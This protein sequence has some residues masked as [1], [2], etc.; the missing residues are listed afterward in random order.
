MSDPRLENAWEESV[1][2]DSEAPL[3][4]KATE[5][6]RLERKA[7]DYC[8]CVPDP[9]IES[10]NLGFM[11]M[12][13]LE[14]VQ[15]RQF[16]MCELHF[17]AHVKGYWMENLFT[18]LPSTALGDK[19]CDYGSNP[20]GTVALTLALRSLNPKIFADWAQ[21]VISGVPCEGL[22]APG[23]RRYTLAKVDQFRACK[24]CYQIALEPL[25]LAKTLLKLEKPR[26]EHSLYERCSIGSRTMAVL[27]A[28]ALTEA[29]WKGNHRVF[30]DMAKRNCQVSHCPNPDDTRKLSR[31]KSWYTFT[32][33]S[34]EDLVVICCEECYV[35]HV[36]PTKLANSFKLV[37]PRPTLV[38]GCDMAHE[39]IQTAFRDA[40]A[41]ENISMFERKLQDLLA[42]EDDEQDT[43]INQEQDMKQLEVDI[44]QCSL[45]DQHIAT[46]LA[47]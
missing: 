14:P 8:P 10:S 29:T 31:V 5:M 34:M 38:D 44:S 16:K 4:I 46:P 7:L 21:S 11:T 41:V 9:T 42:Q 17:N 39:I 35:R 20:T 36:V 12:G 26:L 13:V 47:A 32:S 18:C 25:P 3:R 1:S 40:A 28:L 22:I 6:D 37:E 45:T 43:S 27:Y 33:T 30:V 19:M 23:E 15:G 24:W 2:Q